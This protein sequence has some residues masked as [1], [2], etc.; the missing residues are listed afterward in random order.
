MIS[1]VIPVYNEETALPRVIGH[2][3][4]Q[5][6]EFEVLV[7][8]GGSTDGTCG[9]ARSMSHV[10]LV[11]AP[12]GRASQMN[13]GARVAR[14]GWLL[15]LHADTRLPERA[16]TTIVQQCV[17]RGRDAAGFR[18]RFSGDDWRLKAIS[19]LH[20]TRCRITGILY[21]DQAMLIRA[22]LFRGLGGFPDV[23]ILE[24]LLFGEKLRRVARPALLDSYVV[25]DSRKF[26]QRGIA[27][28]FAQVLVILACHKLR[29]RVRARSF[30]D[31]VR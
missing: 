21:G 23:A 5:A 16:L 13:A 29:I 2:L 15:F 12:R 26:E 22:G 8:D 1:V 24:D 11:A 18:H 28:S 3:A 6:G 4:G 25:T 10:R 9:I 20:N 31:P 19:W 30:F 14:G 27:R 17:E 7:V